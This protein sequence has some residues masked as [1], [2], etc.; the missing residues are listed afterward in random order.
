ME[1]G[2]EINILA[3]R[4]PKK[5]IFNLAS[6]ITRAADSIALNISEGSTG[7]TNTEQKRFLWMANRS[8]L[9][10]VTCLMKACKRD[11]FDLNTYQSKY[12]KCEVLSKMI[13]AFIKKLN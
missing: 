7:L 2:E 6:Q 5:E 3:E 9:E 10:V 1:L 13:Q 4:F 8:I 12:E 11:Y